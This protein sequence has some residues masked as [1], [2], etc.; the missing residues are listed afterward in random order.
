VTRAIT[1]LAWL[2]CAACY[3]GG[4]GVGLPLVEIGTPNDALDFLPL[5]AGG[6]V[7]LETFGQGGT[8]MLI[9][10]RSNGFGKRAYVDVE[11]ENMETGDMVM[12]PPASRPP[13][14]LCRDEAEYTC[15]L[16]P[17]FVLTGGLADPE[18]K[19]GLHVEIRARV[20]NEDGLE[21]EATIDAYLRAS[22]DAA[23]VTEG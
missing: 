5:E 4:D 17:L 10:I 7:S 12:T 20:H 23:Q 1:L 13:L 8:H 22:E 11:V 6:D 14:L 19:D 21:G 2:G 16:I 15:D 3:G 9:A 18:E